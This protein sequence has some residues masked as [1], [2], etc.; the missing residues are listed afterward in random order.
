MKS[1]LDGAKIQSSSASSSSNLQ[2][3]G[4]NKG[5]VFDMSVPITSAEGN[6]SAKSLISV[7]YY[8]VLGRKNADIA[9]I[10]VPVPT[11]RTFFGLVSYGD[12]FWMR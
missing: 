10:P 2:F 3:G 6:W 1:K 4:T 9:H 5:M 11:S 7:S 8:L 12:T